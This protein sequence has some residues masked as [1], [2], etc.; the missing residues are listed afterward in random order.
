MVDGRWRPP[1]Y[2]PHEYGNPNHFAAFEV[3]AE[4]LYQALQRTRDDQEA[5]LRELF[6]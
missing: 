5:A 2:G 3:P 1:Q 6:A 4:R